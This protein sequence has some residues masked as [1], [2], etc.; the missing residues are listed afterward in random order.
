MRY[1]IL[2]KT[3]FLPVLMYCKRQFNLYQM[4]ICSLSWSGFR[5][6]L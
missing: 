4:W 6:S 5:T 2:D 1:S 3:D